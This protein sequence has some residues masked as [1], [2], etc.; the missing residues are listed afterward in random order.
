MKQ[1][2]FKIWLQQ[3]GAEILPVT[4][5]HEEIRFKGSEVGVK[6]KS[7]KFSSTYAEN[8]YLCYK[9]NKKWNGG[10]IST[11]RKV[12]YKKEK[13]Y[14]LKRDGGDCFFC[15]KPLIFDITL[16]HLIPLTSGGQNNLS[17]MVLAHEKCN[18]EVNHKS[19]VEKV[20]YAIK[21]RSNNL[22]D[23]LLL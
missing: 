15:G 13:I 11:G 7:G 23:I 3:N 8:A 10:P 4:N 6:Y 18:Y 12:S 14:L 21:T 5:E 9:N 2:K 1:C 22:K 20:K 17:N 19:I 16:E